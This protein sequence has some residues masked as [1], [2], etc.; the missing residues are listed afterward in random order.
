[1][2]WLIST[3]SLMRSRVCTLGI[4]LGNYHGCINWVMKTCPLL[5][6]TIP[7]VRV[8]IYIK[9]EKVRRAHTLFY[10]SWLLMWCDPWTMNQNKYFLLQVPLVR[11]FNHSTRKSKTLIKMFSSWE[12][13]DSER[14]KDVGN[15]RE[16]TDRMPI[17]CIPFCLSPAS[18]WRPYS[19]TVHCWR[20]R[21]TAL[22]P[23]YV[24]CIVC[25]KFCSATTRMSSFDRNSMAH[26]PKILIICPLT[27][28]TPQHDTQ[29]PKFGTLPSNLDA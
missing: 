5:G 13:C 28:T 16:A 29:H 7:W 21:L 2:W 8:P 6:G 17:F 22:Q 23:H 9:K 3:V 11:A 27:A 1:M 26:Q 4:P 10:A 14:S 20:K 12:D 25:K 18:L 24:F 19:L 15:Y